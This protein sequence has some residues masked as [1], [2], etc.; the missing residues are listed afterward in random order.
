MMMATGGKTAHD[1]SFKSLTNGKEI[2]LS[3][4]KGKKIL[5]VNT[6][7][8]CGYTPQYKDLQT[9]ADQYSGKLVIIGFPTNDF[10]GQE[11]GSNKEIAGFCEKNYGVKF[12]MSEKITVKGDKVHPLYQ[13]LTQ[14]SMNGVLDA[15]VKWNF[16]KFLIDE[17]GKLIA[18]F[19]SSTSPLSNDIKDKLK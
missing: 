17:Q 19:P 3:Q 8:E 18:Y 1:F 11:P 12:P 15:S 4:F 13:W 16:N 6:A 2:S 14:K 9:L 7:S 10:G 5:V